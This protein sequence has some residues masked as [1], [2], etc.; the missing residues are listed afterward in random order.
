M[1]LVVSHHVRME[2]TDITIP[3]NILPLLEA[4]ALANNCNPEEIVLA[5]I[6]VFL[7]SDQHTNRGE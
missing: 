6:E 3:P 2:S 7:E 1:S 5:A 4:T